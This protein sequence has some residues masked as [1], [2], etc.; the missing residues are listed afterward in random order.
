MAQI[1]DFLLMV[2]TLDEGIL[3]GTGWTIVG[4]GDVEI[5]V[6]G[7]VGDQVTAC[8]GIRVLHL[9]LVES[10]IQAFPGNGTL[11]I[12]QDAVG[13]AHHGHLRQVVGIVVGVHL[14]T[15]RCAAIAEHMNLRQVAAQTPCEDVIGSNLVDAAFLDGNLDPLA[16]SQFAGRRIITLFQCLYATS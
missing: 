5:I 16:L 11:G 12:E 15:Q 4:L 3:H 14:L 1:D 10:A 8:C 9:H 6:A 7:I 2:E 13:S